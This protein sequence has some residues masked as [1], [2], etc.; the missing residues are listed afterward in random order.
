M[1]HVPICAEYWWQPGQRTAQFG[2][3]SFTSPGTV[4]TL[5]AITLSA[6]TLSA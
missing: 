3:I 6:I 5:S 1:E 4:I 2:Q